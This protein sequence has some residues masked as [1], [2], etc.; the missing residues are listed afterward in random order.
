MSGPAALPHL[1]AD[2]PFLTDGGLETTLIFGRGVDLPHFAAFVLLADEAGREH[3]RGYFA[4]YLELARERGAGFMLDT[5]TW[6]ANPDWG[7]RL[8]YSRAALA[9]LNR[10][11]VTFARELGAAQAGAALPIVVDGVIGPRGDGYVPGEQMSAD[12]AREYHA[13]QAQAFA[14][15]G[16]DMV[17]AITMTYP[18]EAIGIVQ[19]AQEAGLPAAVSFTVETD[20][21]LPSGQAIGEAIDQVDAA[22]NGAAAYFMI[23]CAHPTHFAD[24]LEAGAPWLE[25][26]GGIRANASTLSH[27]EL[28]E[29]EELD[30]GDPAD[31]AARYTELQARLPELRVV[32]GCCGTDERHIDAIAA[33]VARQGP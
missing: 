13:G 10:R 14:Q 7:E 26:I 21:R 15:S 5:A 18:E 29:A 9:D 12:E 28:D 16:A 1:S 23:N 25:R 4:P 27:A 31:L 8:G 17:S 19:A 3:L 30:D 32:G 20:G 11:A 33:A 24:A 6:R 22:T 2:R